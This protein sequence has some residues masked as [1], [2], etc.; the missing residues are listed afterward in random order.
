MPLRLVNLSQSFFNVV[1][2]TEKRSLNL[3]CSMYNPV[4]EPTKLL[5]AG[6]ILYFCK[7]IIQVRVTLP[8]SRTSRL[9][10]YSD[11]S[12]LRVGSKTITSSAAVAYFDC[13]S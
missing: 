10:R 1:Q 11:R 6:K 5:I 13:R 7:F 12:T 9:S 3:V 2:L 4:L 8:T